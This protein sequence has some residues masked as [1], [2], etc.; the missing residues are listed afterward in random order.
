M[1]VKQL[2][3]KCLD[4]VSPMMT[5]IEPRYY[6]S[7][8]PCTEWDLHQLTNHLLNEISWVPDMLA[9]KTIKDVGNVYDGDLIGD[10]L[11]AN[12]NAAAQK[13][14]A[15]VEAVDLDKEVHLSYANVSAEHYISE[16]SG[17]LLI[18][19]WDIAQSLKSSLMLPEDI[20]E[21]VYIRVLPRAHEYAESSLF[22]P[23]I[24]VAEDAPIRIKLLSI[25]GRTEPS[26]SS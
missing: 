4:H 1:E 10:D 19:G 6:K 22:G 20:T 15:A 25:F 7:S 26:L 23:P 11:V 5:L 17:E 14:L 3:R 16:I 21:A 24:D 2:F 8:T 18:H 12:W 9:G 13:A